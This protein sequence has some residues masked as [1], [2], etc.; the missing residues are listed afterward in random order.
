MNKLLAFIFAISLSAYAQDWGE[1]DPFE[2]DSP[3][4][5]DVVFGEDYYDE[6]ESDHQVDQGETS[7]RIGRTQY[8]SDG[9]TT[10][11]IGGNSY[12]SDGVTCSTVGRNTYCN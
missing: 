3:N 12:G 7:T 9:T 10:T 2:L 8:D 6:D 5:P 11:H 1:D 4:D